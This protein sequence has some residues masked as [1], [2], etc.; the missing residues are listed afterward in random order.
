MARISKD[1]YYLNI[2][3]EVAE[4][5]T[6][7]RR[8][9]G[10]VIVQS[11]QI[12]ST[13]YCGA[14]RGTVNCI[15]IDFCLREKRNAKRGEHYEW[16]RS[17]HAEQNAIIHSKRLDMMNAKLYLM[18]IDAKTGEVMDDAEP[19]KLCQ[20]MIINSGISK[21]IS[22]GKKNKIITIDVEKDWIATNMGEVKKE[23][24]KWIVLDESVI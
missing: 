19:C 11:D 23:K 2:A 5:S 22:Y 3:R 14:P 15:D 9:Y 17:V 7:L 24:G 1:E 6:C 12:I 4:R 18:G 13:G 21:I 20:R 10:A 16:C 8:K